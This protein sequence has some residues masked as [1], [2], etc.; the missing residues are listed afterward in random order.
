MYRFLLVLGFMILFP[1]LANAADGTGNTV[2]GLVYD[3]GKDMFSPLF[4]VISSFSYILGIWLASNA[5]WH[6]KQ[7]GEASHGG[8]QHTYMQGVSRLLGAGALAA[9]PDT[10]NS[11]IMTFLSGSGHYVGSLRTPGNVQSCLSQ[12]ISGDDNAMLC[13]AR[14]VGVNIV[15]VTLD[16][17]FMGTFILGAII[18]G[19]ALYALSTKSQHNHHSGPT[20]SILGRLIVGIICCNLPMFMSSLQSTLGFGNGV[21]T[22]TGSAIGGTSVPSVLAYQAPDNITILASFSSLI[23]WCFVFLSL[24]GVFFVI[25]GLTI[26]YATVSSGR[27]DTNANWAAGVHIVAGICLANGKAS[28]CYLLSSFIGNGV[29]FCN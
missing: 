20:S 27:G 29:G 26:L 8:H 14:N 2:G 23:S 16:F 7:A 18:I 6:L 5:V 11:G 1:G 25:R 12:T 24:F 13:V 9:F 19:K 28:V 15:P 4:V 3:A 22:S 17:V 10:I 21:I